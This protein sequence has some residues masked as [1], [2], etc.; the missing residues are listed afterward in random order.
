MKKT[1]Q[2]CQWDLA[3][4]LASIAPIEQLLFTYFC[5][6]TQVLC[7]SRLEYPGVF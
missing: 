4:I 6:K 2:V 3:V 1:S 5:S 7:K